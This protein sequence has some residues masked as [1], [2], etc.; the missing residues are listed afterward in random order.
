MISRRMTCRGIAVMLAVVTVLPVGAAY[1]EPV[2]PASGPEAELVPGVPPGPYQP[3]QID[4]PDQVLAPKV[5]TPTAT[6]DAAEPRDAMEATYALVEYV[7]LGDAAAKVACSKRTGPYQRQ[8]ERWLKLKVDGKQSG[9]DCLA[10]RGFQTKHKIKPSIGFAGP[11]TW[12]HMQLLS[13][14]KNP[15]AAKKCPVRSYRV[16]CVDLTRQLTWV[17]KGKKVIYG[18]VPMRSGRA[19]YGTRTGWKKVYWKHKNHWSTLY[20]TPM[21]YSQFFD[22]GQAF[23]AVYGSIYTTVGSWGCVNL[24]LADARKLWGVLKKGDRVYVWGRRAGT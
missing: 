20:N 7:P 1:A 3:W 4:T 14:K 22:G 15:N 16:A 18:P 11:V 17:Q 12:A 21:P 23:H 9:A 6:E 19:G 24:R 8:V 2:P 13:A 5:Y 10:I